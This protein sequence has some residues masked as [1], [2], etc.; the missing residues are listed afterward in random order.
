MRDREHRALARSRDRDRHLPGDRRRRGGRRDAVGD[1]RR[2]RRAGA[3]GGRR[4]GVGVM[5]GPQ[6][7]GSEVD[8]LHPLL[9]RPRARHAVLLRRLRDRPQADLGTAAAGWRR[10]AGRLSLVLAYSIGG[11][12]RGSRD[13]ALVALHRL[14]AGDHRDRD[15]DPDPRRHRRAQD[16]L[17]DLPAR[18]R[19][20][21][22][23]RADPAA[24][25]V[26]VQRASTLHHA[27]ILLGFVGLAVGRRGARRALVRPDDRPSRA[28]RSRRARS[29]RCAGSSCSSSRSPTRLRARARP[30]ARRLR[31]GPDHAPG[32]QG[33]RGRRA[34]TPS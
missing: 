5:I 22:R 15:A 28:R 11:R 6:V 17:R 24:D 31:R 9:L 3:D 8:R 20:G 32:A 33:A 13:R 30:A 12:A 1:A 21:R 26:P 34:S 23:V 18:R 7:P 2:A 14:G 19:R 10:S 25:P 29:L 16:A 4:A 27:A